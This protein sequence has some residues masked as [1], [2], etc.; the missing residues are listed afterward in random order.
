M[1]RRKRT[2]FL[3]DLCMAKWG[4]VRVG[5]AVSRIVL[6]GIF[7]PFSSALVAPASAQVPDPGTV[8]DTVQGVAGPVQDVVEPLQDAVDDVVQEA[9]V[10]EAVEPVQEALEQAVEPVQE[11]VEPDDDVAEGAQSSVDGAGGTIEKPGTDAQDEAETDAQDTRGAAE[12]PVG[13]ARGSSEGSGRVRDDEAR[14]AMKAGRLMWALTGPREQQP[15]PED[16]DDL[17]ELIEVGESIGGTFN[18]SDEGEPGSPGETFRL[19]T[20]GAEL[21][22]TLIL[23]AVL[24]ALGFALWRVAAPHGPIR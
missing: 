15:P 9:P 14:G 6:L 8:Q 7:G 4:C 11:A 2:A 23:A 16:G 21:R 20:T 17:S 13:A 22:A 24:W 5:A 10:H 19:P 3:E 12:E 18:A 1:E